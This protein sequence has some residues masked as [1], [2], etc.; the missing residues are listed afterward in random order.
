MKK[1][2][3]T[4][5]KLSLLCLLLIFSRSAKAE[6][7]PVKSAGYWTKPTMSL[8]ETQNLAKHDLL[9]VDLENQFNNYRTLLS[10]KKLNPKLKLICY[11]NPM[12]IFLTKYGNRPWQNKIIEELTINRSAWLLKTITP[13]KKPA[14]NWKRL[15]TFILKLPDKEENYA[16][17]WS[18]M[19]MTN[20][21]SACP[22]INGEIYSNWISKKLTAEILSDPIWDGYFMDNGTA[23][24]SW[25]HPN[26][27]DID[28]DK[29]ADNNKL[30]DQ[31]WQQGMENFLRQIRRLKGKD[32]IILS[33]KGDLN[34]L[35]QV[36]GKL[37]ENFPND[38]LGDKWSGGWRQCL[39]NAK[40]TGKY[41]IFQ[42][43]R[44]NIN[45]GLASALLL[46]NV[47][48]AISQDDA[49]YFLELEVNLG[50][51]LSPYENRGGI[52]YRKYQKAEIMVNPLK[53]IG[54]ITLK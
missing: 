33:N 2:T 20:M 11:S 36:D 47:Y 8:E 35:N 41:T 13:I 42:V 3:K 39:Q 21:S 50:L 19:I 51:P 34:F 40:I 16:I 44:S 7:Y 4:A 26:N 43:N 15:K 17:F 49:G 53:K 10:L 24:I 48:I 9:I 30:V 32:F 37:L 12:E 1:V 54:K 25:I 31:K 45:Y 28:G 27:I 5:I 52:Y 22:K 6:N 38:Y 14:N 18:G 29:S 46:D 23:N